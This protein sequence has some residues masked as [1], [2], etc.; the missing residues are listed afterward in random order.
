MSKKLG[1][2]LFFLVAFLL[3][4]PSSFARYVPVDPQQAVLAD[5]TQAA[6]LNFPA[7]PQGP[8]LFLPNS[9]LFFL[10]QWYQQFKLAIATTPEAKARV[11]AQII[12][13][14]M[15]ELKVMLATNNEKDINKAL[16]NLTDES[17]QGAKDILN[18]SNKGANVEDAAKVLNEAIKQERNTLTSLDNQSI[19]S[20]ASDFQSAQ[21]KARVQKAAV[22]EKLPASLIQREV[23][24]D[25]E[26]EVTAKAEQTHTAALDLED[27][28][29]E[30]QNQASEAAKESQ[31][32]RLEIIEQAI[33]TKNEELKKQNEDNL[34]A[35]ELKQEAL[36]KE[37]ERLLESA[38]QA[39][40]AVGEVRQQTET[41][42]HNETQIQN[43]VNPAPAPQTNSGSNTSGGD[44][45]PSGSGGGGGSSSGDSGSGGHGGGDN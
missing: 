24:N 7:L 20:L 40:E 33:E 27:H 12:G 2:S 3:L 30:L 37:Q 36:K 34:K 42:V 8:G 13:E 28:L 23:E 5:S 16:Q 4:T 10:D 6:G 43:S 38:K 19:G 44:S 32:R 25:L 11:R 21:E 14:R 26:E 18:A 39:A 45:H 22:V 41:T 9:P 31:D 1:I 15:A 17:N 29:K 35:E